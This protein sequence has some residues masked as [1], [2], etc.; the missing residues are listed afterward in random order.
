MR[1]GEMIAKKCPE[2]GKEFATA[3]ECFRHIGVDHLNGLTTE[4]AYAIGATFNL[5]YIVQPDGL[6][7]AVGLHLLVQFGVDDGGDDLGGH[8]FGL[9]EVLFDEESCRQLGEIFEKMAQPEYRARLKG[10]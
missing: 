4:R 7:D 9:I 10:Q 3:A 8:G 6:T 2:C 5:H 1:F